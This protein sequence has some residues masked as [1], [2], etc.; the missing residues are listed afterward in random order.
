MTNM[1]A[2]KEREKQKIIDIAKA[3]AQFDKPQ[4]KDFKDFSIY[5][6]THQVTVVLDMQNDSMMP[7]Q[8]SYLYSMDLAPYEVTIYEYKATYFG[9]MIQ[10]QFEGH[11][12]ETICSKSFTMDES[13]LKMVVSEQNS[14]RD[15]N[16]D[17]SSFTMTNRTYF[18]LISED[19]SLYSEDIAALDRSK[20]LC[21]K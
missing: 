15:T 4:I 6:G 11:S 13:C 10:E 1:V 14:E 20:K 2:E 21:K 3:Y 12:H 16:Q 9:Q 19:F 5:E 8:V 17:E 18:Y 7:S